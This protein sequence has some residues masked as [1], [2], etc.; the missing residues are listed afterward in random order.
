[1]RRIIFIII[2]GV[3]GLIHLMG[4]AKGFD[5]VRLEEL[6]QPVSKTS[7][8][9]WLL[10]SIVFLVAAF[11]FLKRKNFWWI[12]GLCGVLISQV[13]IFVFWEEAKFGNI[14]NL[15]IFI[16]SIEAAAG[17]VFGRKVNREIR[18]MYADMK[19]Q[20]PSIITDD[21]TT[22]LPEPVRNWLTRSGIVGKEGIDAVRLKQVAQM[23]MK[24]E[25]DKWLKA[26]AEQYFSVY[27]PA[28]VWKVNLEMLPLV[29]VVGRDKFMDGK[30][31]ML[32]KLFS[33][34]P[35]VKNRDNEK[36]NTGTLQR[37]LGEIVW[38]PAAALSPYITWE[39]SG[40]LTAKATLAYKGITGTGHFHF[41]ENGDFIKYSAQRYMG[42]GED[43]RLRE[44]II[45][46]IKNKKLN[47]IKI[48]V[49]LE[50][51]WKLEDKNWTWLK[52]QITEIE[53]NNMDLFTG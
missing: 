49:D 45:T 46:A 31:E 5:L 11:Q 39:E 8:M 12:A 51:T 18:S 36:I 1:M 7:G 24:P 10:A 22:H 30:G 43:A 16:V 48:P 44:W 6:T 19:P 3:H 9:V 38:F 33:L 20:A 14:P 52:L 34:I 25:Q 40:P 21:M 32:I 17:F 41:N 2:I 4:F 50:A 53:Y 26:Q 37:Y 29:K 42:S 35:I 23:K 15:V 27:D 47:G 28:F 13:L